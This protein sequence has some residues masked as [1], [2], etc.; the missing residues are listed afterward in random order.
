MESFHWDKHFLTGLAEVD[1]QHHHLVKLINQ[2]GDLIDKNKVQSDDVETL[3]NALAEYARYHFQEEEALM[4]REAVDQRH[5]NKHVDIHNTFVEEVITMHSYMAAEHIGTMPADLLNFLIHWLAYH[6]LVIDKNMAMQISAIR[7][8]VSPADAYEEKEHESDD[9]TKPLVNALNGLFKQ[10]SVRNGEL[11]KLNESL[12]IKVAERTKELSAA[13]HQLEE[14]SLTDAMTGLPNRRHAIQCLARL[15]Q[16]SVT[17]AAAIVCIMIDADHFKQVNDSYG[18]DAGDAVLCE[19]S[20]TL[21]HAVRN[22]DIVCRLGG[23]EFF[24]IC[25][26]TDKEGGLYLAGQ[27]LKS[28]T[29][30]RVPTGTGSWHGSVSIGVAARCVGMSSYEELIKLADD[31]VYVAKQDG[32]CCVRTKN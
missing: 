22:D 24:I 18:H 2:F 27:I 1:E 31:S 21:Q 13:N 26:D 17:T 23:D 14:L 8:G 4:S 11:V 7:S 19:L 29:A 16:E 12:E 9:A 3:F 5:I 30:L 15:W 25:P 6:I 28:V 32:K 20:K 10:L